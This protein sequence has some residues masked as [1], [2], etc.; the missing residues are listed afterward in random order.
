MSSMKPSLSFLRL[1]VTA[2]AFVVAGFESCL[3]LPSPGLAQGS[4]IQVNPWQRQQHAQ[5]HP[6]QVGPAEHR[7]TRGIAGESTS[8][9][10]RPAGAQA[11]S[12]RPLDA[13]EASG[14][15]T[16]AADSSALV[17]T[18]LALA[19]SPVVSPSGSL[20]ATRLR[21]GATTDPWQDGVGLMVSLLAVALGLIA[22]LRWRQNGFGAPPR[23]RSFQGGDA[24]LPPPGLRPRTRHE[25][26][27]DPVYLQRMLEAEQH[28]LGQR[29]PLDSK[30]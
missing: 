8:G 11:A 7:L 9:P 2:A 17:A 1:G 5:V 29:D 3:A 13:N 20:P 23:P 19:P 25:R 4:D 30:L 24:L 18:G 6:A 26:L 22:L 16:P 15:F 28:S 21:A 12:I 27:H 10:R 14:R